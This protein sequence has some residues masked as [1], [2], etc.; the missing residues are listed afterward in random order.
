MTKEAKVF[1]KV[2]RYKGLDGKLCNTAEEL[3]EAKK[4][5]FKSDK[6]TESKVKAD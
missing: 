5:G 2:W 3:E 1:G 4:I 6:P